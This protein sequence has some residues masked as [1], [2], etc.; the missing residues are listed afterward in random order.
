[1]KRALLVLAACGDNIVIEPECPAGTVPSIEGACE[2]PGVPATQCA[3]GFAHDGDAGCAPIL[4]A[5]RCPAGTLALLGDT[6]CR[7]IGSCGTGTW[8]DIPVDATTIYV[9]ASYTGTDA[10]GTREKP[11]PRL[12]YAFD[13]APYH[14]LIAIAAGTYAETFYLYRPVRV[15]GVCAERVVLANT[16]VFPNENGTTLTLYPQAS[17]TE[18]HGFSLGGATNL[19]TGIVVDGASQIVIDHVWFR[20]TLSAGLVLRNSYF[21]AQADVT[22][23]AS[24]F[25][26]GIQQQGERLDLADVVV[27]GEGIVANNGGTF[28]RRAFLQIKSSVIEDNT[29]AGIS[30]TASDAVIDAVVVRGTEPRFD[31]YGSGIAITNGS[32]ATVTRSVLE[33]N[34]DAGVRVGVGSQAT[35][36]ALVVRGTRQ[37]ALERK[38]GHGIAISGCPADAACNAALRTQAIV[39]Q[40]LIED[41]QEAGISVTGA[42]ATIDRVLVRKTLLGSNGVVGDGILVL[43]DGIVATATITR[44]RSDDNVRAG[45]ASFGGSV[46]LG[47]NVLACNSYDLNA[48]YSELL[49]LGANRCGCDAFAA[50][51]ATRDDLDVPTRSW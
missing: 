44:T 19:G 39:R 48:A 50:C 43:D 8:G 10:D 5:A 30:L 47:A 6:E 21:G 14:A 2:T 40:S 42:D 20:D 13:I 15:W 23:R 25:E 49:D 3:L 28:G 11:Y 51:I 17:E 33:A 35:L 41:N 38:A 24:L 1:M 26:R 16:F 12:Q 45:L 31:G 46:T 32:T 34:H 37:R 22:V 9:D 36:D 29:D 27:R 7:P 4:P 18:L